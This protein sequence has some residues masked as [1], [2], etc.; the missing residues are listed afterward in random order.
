MKSK[1]FTETE[2]YE[3]RDKMNV[4][5]SLENAKRFYYLRKTVF[6]GMMRYNKDMKF[7]IPF[8]RYKKINFEDIINL[9][10]EQI[11]K[12]IEIYNQDFSY[13]FEKYNDENNFVFLD[14]H[15]VK[16]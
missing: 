3:I 13:I 6:R 5:N 10:Y 16:I 1:T 4:F 8:G 11:L 15:Y 2:Y 7:N 9:Q 12:K 14:P